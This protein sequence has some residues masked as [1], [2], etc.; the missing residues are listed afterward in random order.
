MEN[1]SL[2]K[3]A[4]ATLLSGLCLAQN[5]KSHKVDI[6]QKNKIIQNKMPMNN[7]IGQTPITPQHVNV[8]GNTKEINT[9]PVDKSLLMNK[10]G[11]MQ[12]TKEI[13]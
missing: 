12:N 2:K 11:Q 9:K 7:K 10:P 3:I 1:I 13:D 8:K 4:F 5:L 6:P